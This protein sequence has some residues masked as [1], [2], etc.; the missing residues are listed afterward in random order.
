MNP[1][2]AVAAIAAAID[3]D[4]FGACE[5]DDEY[6]VPMPSNTP[7]IV[8]YIPKRMGWHRCVDRHEKRRDARKR[9]RDAR[10]R[11]RRCS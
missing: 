11:Q 9:Q 2:L 7:M 6:R 10:K 1:I 8:D 3:G 5:I 4:P